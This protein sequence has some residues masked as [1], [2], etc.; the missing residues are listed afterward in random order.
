GLDHAVLLGV[1]VGLAAHAVLDVALARRHALARRI[2]L[3]LG[4]AGGRGHL[5]LHGLL[6]GLGPAARA[7]DRRL[8]LGHDLLGP[9]LDVPLALA[10]AD[11]RLRLGALAAHGLIGPLVGREVLDLAHLALDTIARLG[12]GAPRLGVAHGRGARVGGDVL[13]V[14]DRAGHRALLVAGLLVE[15]A[16]RIPGHA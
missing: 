9:A 5:A 10:G 7:V 12:R 1:D 2:D 8:C 13:R 4:S 15:L 14:G 3:V 16:P 6:L 11:R